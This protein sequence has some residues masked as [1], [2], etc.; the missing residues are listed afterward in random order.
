MP[1]VLGSRRNGK[2]LWGKGSEWWQNQRKTL[3]VCGWYINKYL[4]V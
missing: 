2:V 4:E 3:K 1:A